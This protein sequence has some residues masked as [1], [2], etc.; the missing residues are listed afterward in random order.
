M[1]RSFL[2]I[3]NFLAEIWLGGSPGSAEQALLSQGSG[4]AAIWGAPLIPKTLA[5]RTI[6]ADFTLLASE[7]LTIT[8]TVTVT[9][10]LRII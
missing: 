9:G 4:A 1:A 2:G 8:G 3:A 6:P 5:S 7:S 10:T